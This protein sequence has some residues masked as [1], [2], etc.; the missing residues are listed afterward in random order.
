MASAPVDGAAR[1]DI[2]GGQQPIDGEVLRELAG[3]DGCGKGGTAPDAESGREI[4]RIDRRAN[5]VRGLRRVRSAPL[6]STSMRGD[7]AASNGGMVLTRAAPGR[8][9]RT[10]GP[11]LEKRATEWSGL[12][13]PTAITGTS[14]GNGSAM[15]PPGYGAQAAGNIGRVVES[16]PEETTIVTPS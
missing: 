7:P 4:V 8:C 1:V 13:P 16:L 10:Q 6:E 9:A 2:V 11:S 15:I 14:S 12:L 3:E 5:V